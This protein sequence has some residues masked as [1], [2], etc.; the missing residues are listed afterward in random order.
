ML[1]F[2]NL[3]HTPMAKWHLSLIDWQGVNTILD[4]GCG[5]G[6]N[7]QR[8]LKRCPTALV[9]GIDYAEESV[10]ASRKMNA[11]ALGKRCFI[12]Q[13]NALSLPFEEGKFDLVTA[14]E[15]VY[16]WPD[17]SKAFSETHRVLKDGGHFVFSYGDRE[18]KAMARW[19]EQIEAMHLLP[20]EE[21]TQMLTEAGFHQVVVKPKGAS[22][23]VEC[24]KNSTQRRKDYCSLS[25]FTF[26]GK[27]TPPQFFCQETEL[28]NN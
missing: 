10:K 24:V 27:G 9:Y 7:I 4:E 22:I 14:F 20:I 25:V 19:E 5:G 18:N 15:T 23:H 3:S 2:M 17:L 13:G 6:K 16:F 26:G 1:W 12:E 8:M 21:V 11:H 28:A